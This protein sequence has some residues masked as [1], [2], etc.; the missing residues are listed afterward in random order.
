VI[1]VELGYAWRFAQDAGG[2]AA[3][4]P[5]R[6]AADAPAGW[7]A[8]LGAALLALALGLA[9]RRAGGAEPAR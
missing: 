1:V 9:A 2:V 5:W 6:V 7:C 4:G 8:A 3:L